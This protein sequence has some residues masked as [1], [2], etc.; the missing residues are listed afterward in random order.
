VRGL[1]LFSASELERLSE[2]RGIGGSKRPSP[3]GHHWTLWDRTVAIVTGVSPQLDGLAPGHI[4]L[5]QAVVP[6]KHRLLPLRDVGD[7]QPLWALR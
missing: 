6:R 2:D 4:D 3:P 7:R 1:H 5:E